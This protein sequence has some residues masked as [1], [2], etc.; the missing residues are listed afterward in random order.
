MNKNK[1]VVFLVDKNEHE[2]LDILARKMARSKGETIRFA[3]R[4][5]YDRVHDMPLHE[6]VVLG[7]QE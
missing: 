7:R 6:A 4:E 3:L 5:L 1:R 2:W